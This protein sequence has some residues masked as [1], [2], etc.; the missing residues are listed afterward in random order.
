[1]YEVPAP[2]VAK[3]IELVARDLGEALVEKTPGS[4][5]LTIHDL[6]RMANVF[7]HGKRLYSI[8][9]GLARLTRLIR[10]PVS[11]VLRELNDHVAGAHID[12]TSFQLRDFVLDFVVCKAGYYAIELY[13]GKL[14][15]DESYVTRASHA[16]AARAEGRRSAL[17]AEPLRILLVG[18]VNAGKSSLVNA[19]FGEVKAAVNV[20][21]TT[22]HV[23]PLVFEREGIPQALVFDTPGYSELRGDEDPFAELEEPLL[24]CDAVLLVCSATSAARQADRHV[25]H[26]LRAHFQTELGRRPPLVIVVLTHIDL[27]R[28]LAEWAPP[29]NLA[30]PATD[31]ARRIA[32]AVSVVAE[33]LHVPAERIVPVCLLPERLYNIEEGL[34]PALVEWL[35][36]ASRA[37]ALRCLGAQRDERY[38]RQVL[39]QTVN[40]GQLL[41]DA[42]AEALRRRT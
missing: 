3:I 13:S 11:A 19:L 33:E 30:E 26:Q 20:A 18:Q 28:P 34:L 35:P 22:R 32:E 38:W 31:K 39:R 24:A 9:S 23:T 2:H 1:M 41:R 25:L 17:E 7:S 14:V 29:Y 12:E 5:L 15:F 42:A 36:E 10:N 16:D 21:P 8:W 6:Q 40:A 37:K 27:L 4:H